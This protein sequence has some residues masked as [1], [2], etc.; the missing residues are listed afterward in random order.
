MSTAAP[1]EAT[2]AQAGELRL[3]RL[4]SLRAIAALGVLTGH[5]FLFGRLAQGRPV[6]ATFPERLVIG[7]GLGVWLFFALTGYLLYRPFARRDF[8]GGPPVDLRGYARNRAFRILP[9]YYAVLVAVLVLQ[10]GGGSFTQWSRFLVLGQSFDPATV[11]T[12]DGPMWSLAIEVQFYVVLPLVAALVARAARGRLTAA[13]GLLLAAGAAAMALHW[14]KVEG[15]ATADRRWE[16]SLPATFGFFVAG[17]LVAL[18]AVAW[19]RRPPRAL[20]G[21]LGRS[22]LWLLASLPLWLLVVEDYRRI[23]L[24][25]VASAVTVGGCVLAPRHGPLTR[26]LEWRPLVLV[27]V[28]SY[29]LYLVHWPVLDALDGTVA[30]WVA[31]LAVGGTASLA[32]AALTYRGI[33]APFLRLR[34]RWS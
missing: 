2:V 16:Y 3:A 34:R 32:L 21:P 26:A 18:T 29:S 7:G 5:A 9:L 17:M 33:E 23:A 11:G 22:D 31:L 28:V 24:A 19:R 25:A 20:A 8:A 10:E 15:A 27:G 1:A 6:S 12:V 4:E 13:A 30:G 14:L